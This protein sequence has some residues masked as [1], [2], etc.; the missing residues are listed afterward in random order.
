MNRLLL[1]L[2][3]LTTGVLSTFQSV[4]L[5]APVVSAYESGGDYDQAI[6]DHSNLDYL[7]NSELF[8]ELLV[9]PAEAIQI[10]GFDL[11][12]PLLS[13]LYPIRAPPLA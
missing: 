13:D 8:V 11:I 6:D 5:V 2:L 9:Q 3:L 1:A 12:E 4:Q 7:L 10:P